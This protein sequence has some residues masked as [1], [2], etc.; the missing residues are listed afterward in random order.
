MGILL[1]WIPF[2][3]KGIHNQQ[4]AFGFLLRIKGI[5]RRISIWDE[6]LLD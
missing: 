2:D 1:K 4:P 6:V 5:L 3:W